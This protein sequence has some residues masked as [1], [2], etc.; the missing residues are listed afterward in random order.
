M[1]E[2]PE[3]IIDGTRRIHVDGGGETGAAWE[4]LP[5]LRTLLIAS[6]PL[7]VLLAINLSLLLV[8]RLSDDEAYEGIAQWYRFV[9]FNLEGSVPTWLNASLWVLAGMVAGYIASHV[10]KHKASWWLFCIVCV[11][12]SVDEA[13]GLHETLEPIGESLDTGLA[14]AWVIPGIVIAALVVLLLVRMVFSLPALARNG[15]ILGGIIFVLG[16]V[17]IET[18]AGFVQATPGAGG[19]Y[20]LLGNVEEGFEIAGVTLCLVSLLWL[21]ERRRADAGTAYRAAVTRS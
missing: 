18:I 12:I 20:A 21:L 13:A 14:Y 10:I 16:S 5:F 3:E 2:R 1:T 4:R 17:G 19:L 6:I 8:V 9:D 11:Y 7:A 15:L